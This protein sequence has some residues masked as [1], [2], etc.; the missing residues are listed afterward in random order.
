MAAAEE[1]LWNGWSEEGASRDSGWLPGEGEA[2]KAAVVVVGAESGVALRRDWMVGALDGDWTPGGGAGTTAAAALLGAALASEWSRTE[3]IADKGGMMGVEEGTGD[4]TAGV[5]AT[6]GTVGRAA[7]EGEGAAGAERSIG[8]T[9]TDGWS[10][11][12]FVV[13]GAIVGE[14][15]KGEFEERSSFRFFLRKPKEGIRR[16]IGGT[17]I[18]ARV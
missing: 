11:L 1:A 4:E 10:G 7:D 3:G 9:G 15:E 8:D 2:V 16:W 13:F 18:N 12:V 5:G 17:G 14:E 6:A